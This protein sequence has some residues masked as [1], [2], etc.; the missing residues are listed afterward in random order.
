MKEFVQD[1][2]VLDLLFSFVG[3]SSNQENV[4]LVQKENL[5]LYHNYVSVPSRY[6]AGTTDFMHGINNSFRSESQ[7]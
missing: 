2:D 4:D 5:N 7:R 3:V 6:T 1:N